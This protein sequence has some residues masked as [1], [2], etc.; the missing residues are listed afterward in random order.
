MKQR[1]LEAEVRLLKPS[2]RTSGIRSVCH[3]SG[4]LKGRL[5]NLAANDIGR[6]S[7]FDIACTEAGDGG[8]TGPA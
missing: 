4:Q 3:Y 5:T 7:E 2:C 8:E 6:G 1:R